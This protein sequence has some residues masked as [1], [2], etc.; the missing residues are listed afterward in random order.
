MPHDHQVEFRLRPQGG[1]PGLP[2][3]GITYQ[4]AIDKARELARTLCKRVYVEGVTTLASA[5]PPK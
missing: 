2:L 1:K 5:D 3:T 4:Q